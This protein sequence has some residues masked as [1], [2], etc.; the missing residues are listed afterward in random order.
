MT[1]SWKLPM[2][3]ALLITA[4]L[5]AQGRRHGEEEEYR[6]RID[7]VVSIS[8]GG[9]VDLSLISGQIS[10]R[11]VK[12]EV[13]AHSVSGEIQIAEASNRVNFESV[14]G[15]VIA[16]RIDGSLRGSVVSADL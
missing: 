12:A 11:D 2:L 15:S 10:V 9:S 1:R 8:R 14:S 5:S 3:A 16:S 7:T 13:E 4:P 6:T